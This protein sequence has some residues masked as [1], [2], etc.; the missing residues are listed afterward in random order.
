MLQN[1]NSAGTTKLFNTSGL[2]DAELQRR[3]FDYAGEITGSQT[4]KLVD[5]GVWAT[6]LDDGTIVNVRNMSTSGIGRWT[7]EIQNSADLRSLGKIFR[8]VEI[9][10]K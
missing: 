9:K 4:L 10:F 5:K 6:K 2:S 1:T 8:D 7:V 3:V